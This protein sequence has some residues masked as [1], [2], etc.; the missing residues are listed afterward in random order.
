[1]DCATTD[2]FMGMRMPCTNFNNMASSSLVQ[3]RGPVFFL[4]LK[5]L[6]VGDTV[7]V[8]GDL[9]LVL[10][11]LERGAAGRGPLPGGA[12]LIMGG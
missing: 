9:D 2:H 6:G 11:V 1:M 7:S 3:T 4:K 8:A 10:L 5:S 12:M